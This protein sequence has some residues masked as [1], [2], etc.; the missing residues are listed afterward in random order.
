M[1]KK[2]YHSFA[3]YAEG[4]HNS[5][6]FTGRTNDKQKLESQREKFLGICPFC[7][8]PNKFIV[9]TNIVA[10]ANE[11]CSGKKVTVKNDDGTE[12]VKYIPYIRM[13][14]DKAMEIGNVLFDE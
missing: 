9:G 3:E 4:E 12:F 5:K 1:N 8:K 13:L 6:P 2:I 7:K 14:S 10:C 11:K